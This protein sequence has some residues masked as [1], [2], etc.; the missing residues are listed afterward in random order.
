[1]NII[2]PCAVIYSPNHST[3]AF[4]IENFGEPDFGFIADEKVAFIQDAKFALERLKIDVVETDSNS[5]TFIKR[6]GEEIQ[7]NADDLGGFWGIILFNAKD[8][9]L[10]MNLE[11]VE[12][13]G[14]VAE[15]F[16][17]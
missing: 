14:M 17:K 7:M 4:L 6:D 10:E 12:A 16:L 8:E 11:D 5:F 2:K 9:P 3:I 13:M 1:M 15:K